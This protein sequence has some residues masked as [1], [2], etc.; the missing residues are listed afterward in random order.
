MTTKPFVTRY[1]EQKAIAYRSLSPNRWVTTYRC[2]ALFS[3]GN[4]RIFTENVT[5]TRHWDE[6]GMASLSMSEV[7]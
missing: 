5:Y 2:R 4:V 6:N 3:D 7:R 1:Y